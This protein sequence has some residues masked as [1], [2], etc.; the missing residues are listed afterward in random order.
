MAHRVGTYFAVLQLFFALTWTVYVIY[1][2]RLAEQVGIPKTWVLWIL[3]FDQLVFVVADWLMG[4]YADRA[5]RVMG[6]LGPQLAR[7]TLLSALA[8]VLLPWV[9]PLASPLLFLLLIFV[10]T[11]TSSALRAPPLVLLDKYASHGD[12]RWMSGLWLFGI[13]MAGAL[14]PILT[15]SLRDAD[16][17]A[18]FVLSSAAVALSAWALSWAERTLAAKP[19]GPAAPPAR[20]IP[21]P[22]FL[23]LVLLAGLG[24]QIHFT[25]NSPPQY[26][27]FVK[28]NELV[29]LTPLF[30]IGFNLCVLPMSFVLRRIGE[31]HLL[32]AGAALGAAAAWFASTAGSIGML[33]A[34]QLA[35]GAA[36]AAVMFGAFSAALTLGYRGREGFASGGMF[37]MFALAT[38]ARI[39]V[40]AL[41]L[42]QDA[43]FRAL[44]VHA[45]ALLWAAAAVLLAG[46]LYARRAKPAL[47]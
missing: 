9:A 19:R 17:R 41:A 23:L 20:R 37:S 45:P 3:L 4:V 38:V 31:L 12:S 15:V 30:W 36:W 34:A 21:I 22:V 8:F 1:L 42:N 46:L 6:R 16:A 25:L 2:P 13:G 47:A 11:V 10:W 29:Y 24:Y 14:A 39:A 40:V 28:P 32:G 18:P 33:V 43:E 27:R 44:L 26:L 7:I 35:A 5:A